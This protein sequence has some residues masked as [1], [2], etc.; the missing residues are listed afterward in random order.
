[1]MGVCGDTGSVSF[2]IVIAVL[3][4]HQVDVRPYEMDGRAGWMIQGIQGTE[5]QFATESMPRKMIHRFANKY[6]I[7][8][9]EFYHTRPGGQLGRGA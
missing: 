4:N 2:E 8:I 3:K 9:H 1:M 5:I 7:P 6:D